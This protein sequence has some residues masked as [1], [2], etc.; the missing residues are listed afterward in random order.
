MS[1]VIV[2]VVAHHRDMTEATFVH[3]EK[4]EICELLRLPFKLISISLPKCDTR[5][6]SVVVWSEW[7]EVGLH[8][9]ISVNIQFLLLICQSPSP[10]LL[11]EGLG[12]VWGVK[13]SQGPHSPVWG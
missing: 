12:C 9:V 5:L 2:Y 1:Q 10:G 6:G 11:K 4:I 13:K 8:F 7:I 3:R